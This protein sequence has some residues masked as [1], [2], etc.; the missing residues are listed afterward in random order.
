MT[1]QLHGLQAG[2]SILDFIYHFS[3]VL[4]TG[5]RTTPETK[6]ELCAGNLTDIGHQIAF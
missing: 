3:N 1:V 2:L 5:I 4:S 6:V